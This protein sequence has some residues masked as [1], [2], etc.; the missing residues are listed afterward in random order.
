MQAEVQQLE[1]LIGL[2]L[3]IARWIGFHFGNVRQV[4]D[5]S[6]GEYALHIG[7]P[8]RIESATGIVTGSADLRRWAFGERQP[9]GWNYDDGNSLQD[10]RIAQLLKGYDTRTRS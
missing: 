1:Q 8:W 7:C 5:G 6:K 10:V 9:Q 4:E 3:S 2:K